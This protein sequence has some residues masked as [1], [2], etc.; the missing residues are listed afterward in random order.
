MN[1]GDLKFLEDQVLVWSEQ[2]NPRRR[3]IALTLIAEVRRLREEVERLKSQIPR[4]AQNRG[5]EI[6]D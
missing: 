2:V 4:D 5:A 6:G 1:E 3:E